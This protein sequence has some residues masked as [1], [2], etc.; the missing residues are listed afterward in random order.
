[1]NT[2]DGSTRI[3]RLRAETIDPLAERE[4][5]SP[6]LLLFVA[7][8]APS[9]EA[10]VERA[11]RPIVSQVAEAVG[12]KLSV[13]E[14][15]P[16]VFLIE[17]YEHALEPE[18][19]PGPSVW[20]DD[21]HD[22]L[23]V[24]LELGQSVTTMLPDGRGLELAWL[25]TGYVVT[26]LER[27]S[28]DPLDTVSVDPSEWWAPDAPAW[29]KAEVDQLRLAGAYGALGAVG[30]YF[31][32][33]EPEEPGASAAMLAHLLA[34][35]A[36]PVRAHVEGWAAELTE[37]QLVALGDTAVG[38]ILRLEQVAEVAEGLTGAALQEAVHDLARGRDTLEGVR[39]VLALSEAA[40]GLRL[41]LEL[42]DEDLRLL[43]RALPEPVRLVD[44]RLAE[45][46]FRDP[47]AWWAEPARP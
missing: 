33:S 2:G 29:L 17:A 25:D 46:W 28:V 34:G 12:Q 39:A 27:T 42:F 30:L 20:L 22:A 32:L 19:V 10:F 36:D 5:G 9:V 31:R 7:G 45:V 11:R 14:D 26:E 44:A 24:Q 15:D 23:A 4:Q 16:S 43:L 8:Q 40:E 41:Q 6:V 37:A 38:E 3:V 21:A 1:M 35:G 47:A 13:Y 18:G